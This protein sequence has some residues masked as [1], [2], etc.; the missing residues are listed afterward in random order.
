VTKFECGPAYAAF[1]MA[2]DGT[3]R[4]SLHGLLVPANAG[5]I[6]AM[7]LTA[8]TDEGARGVLCTVEQSL[9]ALPPIRERHYS[10]VPP[11]LRAI[12]VALLVSAEQA[13]VYEG[14]TQA[15]AASGIMRRAFLWRDE[16]EAW[17]QEQTRALAAN[18]VWWS[19]RRSLP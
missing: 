2:D 6:S 5:A 17:L 19:G 3:L 18:R 1:E 4:A 16:A 12:P 8:G 14:V 9:V 10:Y 15:A 11:K 13:A 7:L